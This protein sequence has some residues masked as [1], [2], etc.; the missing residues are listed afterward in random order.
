MGIFAIQ[1]T[2]AY[3]L[4]LPVVVSLCKS[5]WLNAFL[6]H[7]NVTQLHINATKLNLVTALISQ[8][9]KDNARL[10]LQRV[11]LNL[12]AHLDQK[13]HQVLK[14]HQLLNQQ[15]TNVLTT[16]ANLLNLVEVFLLLNVLN[17]VHTISHLFLLLET[18]VVLRSVKDSLK[19]NGK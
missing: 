6:Q 4:E 11:H 18:G 9:V 16:N 14:A 19:V 17:S 15:N 12:K 10:Q 8:I 13:V 1:S 3:L 7:T 2:N 5:V